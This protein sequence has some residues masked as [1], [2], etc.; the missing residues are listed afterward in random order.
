MLVGHWPLIGN[1]NDYS[2]FGNNATANGAAINA[3]GKIGQCYLFD[4]TD[5]YIEIP[6]LSIF[7]SSFSFAGWFFIDTAGVRDIF[8]GDYNLSNSINVNIEKSVNNQLRLYWNGSP[9]IYTGNN[10]LTTGWNHIV[11]ARDKE[12]SNVKFYVNGSLVYTHSGALTD[13]NATRSHYLGRDSRSGD[14]TPL[15]GRA[16]DVRVYNHALSE[17]EIKELAK[18]KILHYT[19]EDGTGGTDVSGFANNGT[20]Y[21]GSTVAYSTNNKIGSSSMEFNGT[22]G[23]YTSPITLPTY[24]IAF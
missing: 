12:N 5:D 15:A 3:S 24:T 16:N 9:D 18:A 19:F 8:L 13:K 17:Y 2:G 7:S 22:G 20:L 11:V 1:T 21:S 6:T 10:V 14:G 4:G 23:F